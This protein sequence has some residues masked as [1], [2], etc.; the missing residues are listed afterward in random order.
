MH[1]LST[2]FV[3]ASWFD[4]SP[5]VVAVRK[6][7]ISMVK[8]LLET[9]YDVSNPC[10]I[11]MI[12]GE[13]MLT[14]KEVQS[15]L[16]EA[17][18]IVLVGK[19]NGISEGNYEIIRLLIGEGFANPHQYQIFENVTPSIN[20][21]VPLL[22]AVRA[23]DVECVRCM[24][25]TYS[26]CQL[27]SRNLERNDPI[28]QRKPESYFQEREAM[29]AETVRLSME[30]ATVTALFLLWKTA[31]S[32]YGEIALF[33]FDRGHSKV[34]STGSIS[35]R[36]IHWLHRSMSECRLNSTCLFMTE[37]MRDK[38]DGCYFEAKL[39]RYCIPS[40]A[41]KNASV[42]LVHQN[43]DTDCMDWS[44][45]L[46]ELPWFSARSHRVQCK[47]MRTILSKFSTEEIL[48]Y[49]RQL[50]DDEFYLVVGEAK[51]LAHKSIVSAR[52]GKLAAH[53]RFVES[54]AN[55]PTY[56]GRLLVSVDIP[57]LAAMMLLSHCY[58]GSIAFGLVKS[59]VKQC[60]Q[61]L[62]MTLLAEEYLCP[63]LL[64]ECEL[65]L[66][67]HKSYLE[68]H[69]YNPCIC[70]QCLEGVTLSEGMEGIHC[71]S[72]KSSYCYYAG[73]YRYKTET[74][75]ITSIDRASLITTDNCLDV[76]A[77][78]QQL[79]SSSCCSREHY[80]LKYCYSSGMNDGCKPRS[81]CGGLNNDSETVGDTDVRILAPFDAAKMM[82]VGEMLRN[83]PAVLRSKS[84][85]HQI[86]SDCDDD[87]DNNWN[88]VDTA[89]AKQPDARNDQLTI[90]LL[91]TCLEE[92]GRSPY[93]CNR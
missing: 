56:D 73:V 30:A 23:A 27:E 80:G 44:Y 53:I 40:V 55:E 32:A 41:G 47:W 16:I 3:T 37:P 49:K 24:V 51:L 70:M 64:I 78:A 69:D 5:L 74:A 17:I 92:L 57:F 26:R 39:V 11:R 42:N 6:N 43:A 89:F 59:P 60:D 25:T 75:V 46:S 2:R 84:Y 33:L 82:A 31:R 58:H 62:E 20:D 14:A 22:V 87:G 45:A 9:G 10:N 81:A 48:T 21:Q 63:S 90:R 79:E 52:S 13:G 76:I 72:D 8:L 12:A 88:E 77:I 83:Y 93:I 54:H 85:L 7:S 66:L 86:S 68:E 67:M 91:Q 15:A 18:N 19:K 28:L 61:L 34:P 29:A 36:A 35:Q 1:L 71:G 65:R 4:G 50:V 38:S